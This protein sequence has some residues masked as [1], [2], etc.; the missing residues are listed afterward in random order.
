MSLPQTFKLLFIL[1]SLF[2]LTAAAKTDTA[3][4]APAVKVKGRVLLPDGSPAKN[5]SITC[6]EC[7]KHSSRRYSAQTN[8]KGEYTSH[9]MPVGSL[10]GVSIQSSTEKPPAAGMFRMLQQPAAKPVKYASAWVTAE[11]TDP[12]PVGQFDIQLKSEGINLHGKVTCADGTPAAGKTLQLQTFPL[13]KEQDKQGHYSLFCHTFVFA[14]DKNGEFSELVPPGEYELIL[15]EKPD[16]KQN[17]NLKQENKEFVQNFTLPSPIKATVLL[18]DG[19]PA[20]NL[21]V[22][23][24]HINF[25][26][27]FS[28][29]GSSVMTDKKGEFP[30]IMNADF[31]V[32][33]CVTEDN[34]FGTVQM[35]VGKDT[36]PFTMTLA[37]PS[38]VKMR[39]VN[40]D[41]K[42][43]SDCQVS[44]ERAVRYQRGS[45][46]SATFGSS[47]TATTDR[48]GDVVLPM[49]ASGEYHICTPKFRRSDREWYVT[50]TEPEKVIDLGEKRIEP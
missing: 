1:L 43:L 50:V 35:R 6:V 26:N 31:V 42:P 3:E 24:S 28:T 17:V 2:A 37:P 48:N 44:Y 47:R 30:V 12:Y 23:I 13:R 9:E 39:L 18:P 15:H 34:K 10:F 38:Q 32:F 7:G 5:I 25:M 14:T 8:D 36:R 11:A 22:S 20:S 16:A 29:R 41:G 19:S 21:R 40:V 4:K 27:N 45:S 33:D 46:R 49:F